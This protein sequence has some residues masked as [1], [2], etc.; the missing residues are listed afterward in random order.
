MWKAGA[1]TAYAAVERPE[2][3]PDDLGGSTN[4]WVEVGRV[5]IKVQPMG[6]Y[7]RLQH[8]KSNMKTSHWV[9]F[10]YSYFEVDNSMRLRILEN[11]GALQPITPQDRVFFVEGVTNPDENQ[12]VLRLMVRETKGLSQ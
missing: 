6:A 9:T 8:L 1:I 12:K 11:N 7:E 10:R 2:E 3:V 5:F 4:R